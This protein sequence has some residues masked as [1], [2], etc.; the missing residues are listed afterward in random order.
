MLQCLDH[1]FLMRRQLGMPFQDVSLPMVI[2]QFYRQ[3][4]HRTNYQERP[5]QSSIAGANSPRSGRVSVPLRCQPLAA[6]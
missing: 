4:I 2:V 6:P 5:F 3:T 1:E